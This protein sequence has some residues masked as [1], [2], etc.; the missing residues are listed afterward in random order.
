[1]IFILILLSVNGYPAVMDF[2]RAMLH[3]VWIMLSQDVCLSVTCRY[4]VEPTKHIVKLFLLFRSFLFSMPNDMAIF[5]WDPLT[6]VLNAGSMKK[7]QLGM[8]S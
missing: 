1:V 6:G 5:W 3:K 8:Q 2:Y 7:L 4:S